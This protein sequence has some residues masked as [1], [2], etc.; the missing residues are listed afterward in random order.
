M[1]NRGA[2]AQGAWGKVHGETSGQEAGLTDSP[3]LLHPSQEC[4]GERTI[5]ASPSL[6]PDTSPTASPDLPLTLAEKRSF[7]AGLIRLN[8]LD[9]LDDSGAFDLARA[10]HVL[11]GGGVQQLVVKE[12]ERTDRAGN[13]TVRREIRVRLVDKVRA[14]RVD[15]ALEETARRRRAEE[16]K[17][18]RAREESNLESQRDQDIDQ[19]V[20]SRC[21]SAIQSCLRDPKGM[22]LPGI[23]Y[24][25]F[26]AAVAKATALHP[27]PPWRTE[28]AQ[29]F[30][31]S[32]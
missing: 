11:A 2:T 9:C 10:R 18:A 31:P 20:A 21:W 17:A 30:H 26:E 14:L 23:P 8:L 7:L 24:E 13:T 5:S 3:R 12:V 6:S 28:G 4:S 29:T 22:L 27:H 1:S 15:G 32:Q 16:E 19:E 25:T